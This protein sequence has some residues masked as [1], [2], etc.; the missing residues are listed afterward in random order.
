MDRDGR[1][2]PS[3]LGVLK[4]APFC[5][6]S[7]NTV[8]ITAIDVACSSILSH[9]GIVRRPYHHHVA[10][11]VDRV[12]EPAAAD[13]T[14]SNITELIVELAELRQKGLISEEE[15]QAKKKQLLER[16]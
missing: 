6:L 4:G 7:P 9:A 16:L 11:D 8:G 2:E 13:A 3:L 5:A 14:A 1:S 15:F 10:G 12:S